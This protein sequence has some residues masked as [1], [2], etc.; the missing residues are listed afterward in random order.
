MAKAF[1]ALDKAF[2]LSVT[3]VWVE[4]IGSE[5]FIASTISKHMIDNY[6]NRMAN[7][8]HRLFIAAATGDPI[9]LRAEI[10]AFGPAC[11]PG[12]LAKA[13]LEPFVALGGLPGFPFA[14]AFVG[15]RADAAPGGEV[16]GVGEVAHVD[17]D[18]GDDDMGVAVVN[19]RDFDQESDRLGKRGDLGLDLLLQL[20]DGVLGL[21]E[22]VHQG[23]Q[24]EA[25]AFAD[26]AFERGRQLGDFVPEPFPGE[27]VLAVDDGLDHE[28]AG[29]FAVR[30]DV[31]SKTVC[32]RAPL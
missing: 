32:M 24:H 31:D 15:A 8:D 22:V 3:I 13:G 7:S 27:V 28:P 10:G 19:P 16:A 30:G 21:I 6:Q 25:M 18:F 11:A 26:V 17:S 20:G 29:L 23:P 1:K 9:K 12:R 14:R 4:I 2:N 5:V